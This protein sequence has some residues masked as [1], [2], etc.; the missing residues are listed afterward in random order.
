MFVPAAVFSAI[1]R[2]GTLALRENWRVVSK[3][4]ING[5]IRLCSLEAMEGR[6]I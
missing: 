6:V 3:I 1:A 5:Y 4:N 2:G